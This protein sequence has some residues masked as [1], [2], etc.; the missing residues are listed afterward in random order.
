MQKHILGQISNNKRTCDLQC[1]EGKEYKIKNKCES[2]A[3]CNFCQIREILICPKCPQCDAKCSIILRNLTENSESSLFVEYQVNGLQLRFNYL[4][5]LTQINKSELNKYI[6]LSKMIP[7]CFNIIFNKKKMRRDNKRLIE[8]PLWLNPAKLSSNKCVMTKPINVQFSIKDEISGFLGI[9]F[10][11]LKN[12]FKIT[13][14]IS[15]VVQL[16]SNSAYI[17]VALLNRNFFINYLF[18]FKS[19]TEGFMF[20][21]NEFGLS[22]NYLTTHNLVSIYFNLTKEEEMQKFEVLNVSAGFDMG[23]HQVEEFI[24]I[25][26]FFIGLLCLLIIFR[27]NYFYFETATKISNFVKKLKISN[28]QIAK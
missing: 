22:T 11:S 1:E 3:N 24:M 15:L 26:Y 16:K 5:I 2:C 14:S 19:E 21:F 6:S 4:D 20:S 27:I 25:D 28:N 7:N 18:I 9:E 10:L 8:F 17:L 13:E 23:E 12:Y